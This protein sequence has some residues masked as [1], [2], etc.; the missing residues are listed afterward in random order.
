MIKKFMIQVKIEIDGIPEFTGVF[1][2]ED[3]L[4]SF[5]KM[6]TMAYGLTTINGKVLT[7]GLKVQELLAN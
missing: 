4:D 6:F 2:S 5:R 3:H 1:R 7:P